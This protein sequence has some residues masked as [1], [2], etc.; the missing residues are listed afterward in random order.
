MVLTFSDCVEYKSGKTEVDAHRIAHVFVRGVE[1]DFR[2]EE[3]DE[4]APICEGLEAPYDSDDGDRSDDSYIEVR[5]AREACPV[6]V[7]VRHVKETYWPGDGTTV[8]GTTLCAVE[9]TA[10]PS[11]GE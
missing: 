5:I 7:R 10:G 3:S 9:V 11:E 1:I 4:F 6:L 8:G 2:P